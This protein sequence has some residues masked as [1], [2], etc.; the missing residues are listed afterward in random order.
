MK[1]VP[2]SERLSKEIEQALSGLGR[3]E[4]ELLE[5]LI[6]KLVKMVMQRILE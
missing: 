3:E 6:E 4:G 5:V 2:P 1:K